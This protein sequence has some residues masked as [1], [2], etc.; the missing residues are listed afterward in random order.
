MLHRRPLTHQDP[1]GWGPPA[2]PGVGAAIIDPVGFGP[3]SLTAPELA[4]LIDVE[5]RDEPFLAFRDAAGDLRFS[6]LAQTDRVSIGRADDN[7]LVLDW[8]PQVSRA[9]AQLERGGGGWTLVDD[10]LSRN[11]CFVNGER[12][13]GRLRLID[14]SMLRFGD[15]AIL[16]APRGA[17]SRRP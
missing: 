17:E 14:G 13:R 11:G 4:A 2:L 1:E 9:H 15:T 8:D 5:R 12:V 6:P 7:D 3:H 10:G 16:F